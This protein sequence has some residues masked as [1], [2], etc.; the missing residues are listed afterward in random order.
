VQSIQ[1]DCQ[2][3]LDATHDSRFDIIKLDAK[4]GDAGG[5]HAARLRLSIGLGQC[6]GNNS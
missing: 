1:T 4:L 3:H 5:D 6:H 2:R